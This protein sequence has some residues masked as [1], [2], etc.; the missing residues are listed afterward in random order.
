MEHLTAF[1]FIAAQKDTPQ[2]VQLRHVD[3]IVF[4]RFAFVN[5]IGI[6]TAAFAGQDG[7]LFADRR[8][9]VIEGE[10]LGHPYWND[11]PVSWIAA[12]DSRREA[13]RI[14]TIRAAVMRE[15]NRSRLVAGN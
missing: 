8:D 4:A 2:I 12:F 9:L 7:L 6:E 3:G 11:E 1:E 14:E 13:Q 5:W 10:G 15:I